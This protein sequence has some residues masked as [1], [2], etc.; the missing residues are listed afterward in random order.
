MK[1]H[2]ILL[3]LYG[4]SFKGK[5]KNGTSISL[6]PCKYALFLVYTM[7]RLSHEYVLRTKGE[8]TAWEE[9]RFPTPLECMLYKRQVGFPSFRSIYPPLHMYTCQV[10]RSVSCLDGSV[11]PVEHAV[12]KM[13]CSE[14]T[15]SLARLSDRSIY[16]FSN[17]QAKIYELSSI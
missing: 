3:N 16:P 7:C 1:I 6:L 15:C 14:A 4:N 9:L 17:R 10:P 2:G 12:F 11:H 8:K 13:S 5:I